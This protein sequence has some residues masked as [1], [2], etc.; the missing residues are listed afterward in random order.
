MLS[1]PQAN[2]ETTLPQNVEFIALSDGVWTA[3]SP[4]AALATIEKSL[5]GSA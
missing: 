4:S 1:L 3:S 2:P 5:G